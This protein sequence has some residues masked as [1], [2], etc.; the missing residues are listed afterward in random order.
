MLYSIRF[1]LFHIALIEKISWIAVS[2]P[3]SFSNS[4][5]VRT[6][7]VNFVYLIPTVIT[8]LTMVC[9]IS[10]FYKQKEF[11]KCE[12]VPAYNVVPKLSLALLLSVQV[13]PTELQDRNRV[14]YP[15]S[16]FLQYELRLVGIGVRESRSPGRM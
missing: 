6:V 13:K 2:G 7:Y 11:K 3:R 8:P 15:W 12:S 16:G 5:Q 9:L 4:Y 1:I 14:W 10:V